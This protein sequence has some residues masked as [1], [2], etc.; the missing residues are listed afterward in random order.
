MYL[1]KTATCLQKIRILNQNSGHVE[2]PH[3]CLDPEQ[4]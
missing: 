1:K 4:E 2:T 3:D